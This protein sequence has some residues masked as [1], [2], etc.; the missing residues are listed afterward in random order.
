MSPKI[1]EGKTPAGWVA[2]LAEMGITVSERTLRERARA[3]GACKLLGKTMILLPEH[4]DQL[5][6]APECR[7]KNTSGDA[8][9]GFKA[10]LATATN[11]SEKALEHLTKLSRKPRSTSSTGRRGN[12]VSLDR[13]LP[14]R[15]TN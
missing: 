4:I 3:T 13:M 10:D 14:S 7:S 15:K 12:V 11:T 9:G 8:S 5:F 2:Y 1:A 6:E